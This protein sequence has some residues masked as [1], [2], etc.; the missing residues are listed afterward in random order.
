MVLSYQWPTGTIYN[1]YPQIRF[2]LN[3]RV[4]DGSYRV[5]VDGND[6]SSRVQ[7]NGQYYY[8]TVPFSLQMGNHRVR[9]TGQTAAGANFNLG[10]DF[11]QGS[12]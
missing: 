10:W 12:Y 3:R 9:I 7:W 1:H 5:L 6:V 4:A 2:S 11:N 8:V